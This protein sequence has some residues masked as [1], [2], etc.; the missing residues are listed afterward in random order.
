MQ[1][2]IVRGFADMS[3]ERGIGHDDTIPLRN[4]P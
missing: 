1:G 4:F 2:G 3:F